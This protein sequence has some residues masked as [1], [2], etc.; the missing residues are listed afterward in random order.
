MIAVGTSGASGV[1]L[2]VLIVVLLAERELIRAC[3]AGRASARLLNAALVPLM[4]AW[5]LVL[6]S[7]V[8]EW[9]R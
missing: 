8:S 1:I 7:R 2:S 4:L 3:V 9:L 6:W 5:I